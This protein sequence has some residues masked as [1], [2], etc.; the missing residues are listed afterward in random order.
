MSGQE[1]IK[2]HGQVHLSES[3]TKDTRKDMERFCWGAWTSLGHCQAWQEGEA[4]AGST[5]IHCTDIL[6]ARVQC[7]SL[8]GDVKASE[9]YEVV[10]VHS[11][12]RN[13]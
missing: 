8:C 10:S 6:A 9:T 7:H 12:G 3:S 2:S 5:Q 11:T 13:T 1:V 4:G